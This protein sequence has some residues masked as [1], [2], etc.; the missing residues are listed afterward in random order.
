MLSY[1]RFVDQLSRIDLYYKANRLFK[2]N[3]QDE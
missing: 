2:I 1:K 3:M